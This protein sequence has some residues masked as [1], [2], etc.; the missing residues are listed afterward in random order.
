MVS[1]ML[2]TSLYSISVSKKLVT[3]VNEN[4]ASQQVTL[5]PNPA[6]EVLQL[7]GLDP[8]T[9]S[10]QIVD[11]AG[12]VV[13]S[14]KNSAFNAQV[15]VNHLAKGIYVLKVFSPKTVVTK[16]FQKN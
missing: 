9:V 14:E 6:S 16:T 4:A 7:K 10:Y 5:F 12:R 1:P 3:G 8:E 13:A 2:R 11:A 15:N